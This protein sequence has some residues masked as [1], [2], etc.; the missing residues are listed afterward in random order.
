[1]S[2]RWAIAVFVLGC[3]DDPKNVPLPADAGVI[4]QGTIAD[5]TRVPDQGG[6]DARASDM[7]LTDALVDARVAD[8]TPSIDPLNC[9]AIEQTPGWQVCE[10]APE[11]CTAV[12]DDGAGCTAVCA[13]AG[14]RCVESFENVDGECAADRT[15]PPLGCTDGH[16]SDFC[17]CQRGECVPDCEGRACGADGCGDVC[18]VCAGGTVCRG[19]SCADPVEI[20]CIPEACPSFSVVEG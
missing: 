7:N 4:D 8:A 13:A 18:G 2:W 19:G 3:T 20:L 11:R 5:A 6:L 17:V 15:R 14:M 16:A 12:F 1:M 10:A 9:D